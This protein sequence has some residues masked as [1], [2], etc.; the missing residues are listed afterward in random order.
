VIGQIHPIPKQIGLAARSGE[1]MGRDLVPMDQA[2]DVR[3]RGLRQGGGGQ[4]D[5]SKNERNGCF[6]GKFFV[7]PLS[8]FMPAGNEKKRGSAPE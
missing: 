5:E 7:E 4:E 3:V 6:H 1:P 2:G 8:D